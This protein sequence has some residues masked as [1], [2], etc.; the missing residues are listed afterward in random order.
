M[1]SRFEGEEGFRRLLDLLREQRALSRDSE[2]LAHAIAGAADIREHAAGDVLIRQEDDGNDVAFLLSGSVDILVNDQRVA[3]RAAGEHVGEMAAIDPKAKRSATVKACGTV[4]AAWVSEDKI[5]AIA[6]KHPSL[7]RGF[8]RMLA[9]RL[10]ERG[11]LVRARNA[12]PR[13]F[14]GCSVEGLSIAQE[15]Q[16]GLDHTEVL[17]KIWTENV[18]EAS[19]YAVPNLLQEAQQSDFAA[20]V[21][22][23]EDKTRSRGTEADSPRDNVIFELGMFMGIL[24]RERT[25]MVKPR[26]ANLKIPS[27]LL[28]IKP[29]D[30]AEPPHAN[31]LASALGRICT[32]IRDMIKRLGAR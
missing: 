1:K 27:D 24:G 18:F 29:L 17:V 30:F 8:A 28:G 31:D 6:E 13:L 2:K 9:D 25:V 20:F 21:I 5:A 23:G 11:S 4:I 16:R 12:K 7:W 32:D 19:G 3:G 26:G 10:R 15:L 22:Q 14:V